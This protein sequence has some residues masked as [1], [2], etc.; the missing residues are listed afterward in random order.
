M[1]DLDVETTP[2]VNG[3]AHANNQTERTMA[4]SGAGPITLEG[5]ALGL[6]YD[7]RWESHL[8]CKA[9]QRVKVGRTVLII[10]GKGCEGDANPRSYLHQNP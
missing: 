1:S 3:Q 8:A 9:A 2:L 10:F 5:G 4:E 6:S 7:I